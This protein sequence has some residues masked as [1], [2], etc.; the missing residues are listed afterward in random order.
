MY[1]IKNHLIMTLGVLIPIMLASPELKCAEL[2]PPTLFSAGGSAISPSSASSSPPGA[3]TNCPSL[4]PAGPTKSGQLI[5]RDTDRPDVGPYTVKLPGYTTDLRSAVKDSYRPYLVTA[6]PG[7]TLRFDIVNQLS[8]SELMGGVVNLHTHGLVVSPRPCIPLGDYAFV[9]DLPFTTTSY[10]IDIPTTLPGKMY[11]NFSTPQPYP[12]GLNWFHAHV[13]SK[14]RIDVEGGQGGMLYIGDLRADLL[15]LPNLP[16]TAADLLYRADVLYLGLRDIQLSVPPGVTPDKAATGTRAQWLSGDDYNS[17]LCPA[18]ANPPQPWAD[19]EFSGPGYCGVHGSDTSQPDTVWMFTINGQYFPTITMR[20]GHD[21]IWRIANLSSSLAYVLELVDDA[22]GK[23]QTVTALALDGLI[24]GT[25]RASENALHIGVNLKHVL[26]MPASRAELFVSN[27]AGTQARTMT[28]RT[29]GITTGP[30]GD[31]WPRINIA[32]VVMPPQA[33][34]GNAG[35]LGTSVQPGASRSGHDAAKWWYS[36]GHSR[37]G[38]RQRFLRSFLRT[39]S[40]CLKVLSLA[41]ESRFWK[42]GLPQ[43][44]LR[45]LSTSDSKP[46]S[47]RRMGS[48][49]TPRI[50]FHSKPFR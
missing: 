44:A 38:R 18:R 2:Q 34:A 4:P 28:L 25:S 9:H 42:T 40:F 24:A 10:R 15:A 7:N 1:F 26:L 27:S 22:T 45:N 46:K 48:P 19:G 6:F 3:L 17:G 36:S 50:R 23:P 16:P 41:A 32:S 30:A 43:R 8:T 47:L 11:G 20:P 33:L 39:A 35:S 14:S 21:Q 12:S 37:E 49:S 13:H 5:I 29:A 31:P